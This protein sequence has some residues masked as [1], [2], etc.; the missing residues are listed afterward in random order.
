MSTLSAKSATFSRGVVLTISVA[1]L[2]MV[3]QPFS[4]IVFAIGCVLAFASAL[5]FNL[6]PILQE[7]VRWALVG[8]AALIILAVFAVIFAL[9]VA[10]TYGYVL[11][12]QAQ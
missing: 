5:V 7:G 1:A 8:R 12:L 11:Y 4:I 9:A 2:V 6:M 3:F 10:A